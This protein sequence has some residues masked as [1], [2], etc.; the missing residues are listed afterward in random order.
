MYSVLK[1]APFLQ[2]FKWISTCKIMNRTKHFY[3]N[4]W[5]MYRTRTTAVYRCWFL[6]IKNQFSSASVLMS[7]L[8]VNTIPTIRYSRKVYL[9]FIVNLKYHKTWQYNLDAIEITIVRKNNRKG[10][11]CSRLHLENPLFSV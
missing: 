4:P 3:V 2:Y 10:M 7:T 1:C 6:L 8:F 11:W 9:F 5:K